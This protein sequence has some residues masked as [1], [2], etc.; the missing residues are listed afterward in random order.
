MPFGA[1]A[2]AG[3]AGLESLPR[4]SGSTL[5]TGKL[6]IPEMGP[7]VADEATPC[8]E[9]T[10]LHG[11]LA[12]AQ[13]LAAAR[14]HPIEET[15][16]SNGAQRLPQL[17]LC[18]PKPTGP[19]AAQTPRVFA[20]SKAAEK[21]TQLAGVGTTGTSAATSSSSSMSSQ[22]WPSATV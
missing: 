10:L 20:C 17:R 8:V 7:L 4:P 21:L 9:L 6:H 5:P 13:V 18:Q 3:L 14:G 15:G 16:K 22:P 11:R 1:F 19:Q 2:G 12:V